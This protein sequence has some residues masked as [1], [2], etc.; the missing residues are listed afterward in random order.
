[1]TPR[2]HPEERLVRTYVVTDGRA[3]PTRNTLEPDTLLVAVD[4][5]PAACPRSEKRGLL[6][7]CRGG[8]VSVAEAADHLE[9][10]VSVTKVLVADLVDDGQLVTRPPVPAAR[11]TDPQI[12][13]E[14]L[15]ALRGRL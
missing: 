12:L 11:P 13:Q 7:L 5:P 8:A 4:D 15:D 10:P 2:R 3:H 14:V 1:V 9:L 6:E